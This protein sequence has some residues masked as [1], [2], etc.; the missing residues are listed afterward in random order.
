MSES[1]NV[2]QTSKLFYD[3]FID[4]RLIPLTNSPINITKDDNPTIIQK[5]VIDMGTQLNISL[6]PG[7]YTI[8]I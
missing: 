8:A 6:N 4:K 7:T 1:K 5:S 3:F 2:I